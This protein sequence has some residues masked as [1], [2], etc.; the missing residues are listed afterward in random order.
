M[1][2][3]RGSSQKTVSSN[4]KKLKSEGYSQAQATAIALSEASRAKKKRSRKPK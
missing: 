1:P 2:I 4:I 3:K